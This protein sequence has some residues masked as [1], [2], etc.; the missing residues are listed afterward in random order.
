MRP[1]ERVVELREGT[2]RV[3]VLEAGR[4]PVLVHLHSFH[5]REPW[6][7]FLDRLAARFTV[8]APLHPG[9]GGSAGVEHLEDLLDL[10]LVYDELLEA[11]GRGRVH[12]AGH[13]FGGLVAAEVAA[14]FPARV[15]R[16]VLA[17]P[18]GL[19][20]DD[21]P[22][23]DLLILPEE[24]LLPALWADPASAVA[25]Q[26]ATLPDSEE[27]NVA[28]Q[29]DSIT[30]RAAMGKFVWPIPD[31]GLG[32]RLHRVAAPALLL[33]GDAD[34]AN[35]LVYAEDWQRRL[36]GAALRVL[37]GGHML[38]HESSEACAAAVAEFLA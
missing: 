28:A 35:P 7:P 26:W 31:K 10:T 21:A 18:L 9:A 13:G 17:S 8:L 22:P 38:L 3:R 23:A 25:R 29:I 32:R 14:L 12:L 5:E 19:W 6:S 37:P 15:G 2:V 11:L 34:R 20:R 16:L 4:G 30:R 1:A 36:K 24:D 27:E 33:W